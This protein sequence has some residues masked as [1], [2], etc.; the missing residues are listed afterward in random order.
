MFLQRDFLSRM[1]FSLIYIC[2]TNSRGAF[3]DNTWHLSH[4][5]PA[6]FRCILSTDKSDAS[7]LLASGSSQTHKGYFDFELKYLIDMLHYTSLSLYHACI[8]AVSLYMQMRALFV[9]LLPHMCVCG[10]T[11]NRHY[12]AIG[13]HL[14]WRN[15]CIPSHTWYIDTILDMLTLHIF[16]LLRNNHIPL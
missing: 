14:E 9:V 2:K 12:H 16:W 13:V 8:G 10:F 6:Q 15:T 11:I 7:F 3:H 1:R 5:L 4:I